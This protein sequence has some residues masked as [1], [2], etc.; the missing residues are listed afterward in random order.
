MSKSPATVFASILHSSEVTTDGSVAATSD[1]WA[2]KVGIM[3]DKPDRQVTLLDTGG[4]SN[5]RWLLDYPT[6]QVIVRSGPEG[7][8]EG[9]SKARQVKDVLLGIQPQ[10]FDTDNTLVGIMMQSDI[11]FMHYDDSSRAL[12][13]INFRSIVQP[14]ASDETNRADLGD[15]TA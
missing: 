12:F 1:R 13:S 10:V 14:A 8:E 11:S 4:Y 5:P 9:Y 7:Y 3:Q 2:M 15:I 6:V